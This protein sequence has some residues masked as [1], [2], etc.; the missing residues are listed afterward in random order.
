MIIEIFEGYDKSHVIVG[1]RQGAGLGE[2]FHKQFGEVVW[3]N[4]ANLYKELEKIASWVNN[5]MGEE[6]MFVLS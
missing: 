2:A 3:L 6:C 4:T 1:C 5:E